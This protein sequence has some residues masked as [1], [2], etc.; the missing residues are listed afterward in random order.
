MSKQTEN[1]GSCEHGMPIHIGCDDC[2]IGKLVY[3]INSLKAAN[4]ELLEALQGMIA[5][6]GDS[7]GVTGYYPNG[8]EAYWDEFAEVDATRAAIAKHKGEA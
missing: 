3:E 6:V 7:R 2:T 1:A 8:N 4:A 5:I